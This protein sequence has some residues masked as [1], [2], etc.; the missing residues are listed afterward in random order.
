M[1]ASSSVDTWE[2][3]VRY[4][5]AATKRMDAHL[6]A[7]FG[8]SL[9]DYD[10]LR[11]I[12]TAGEPIR[13]GDLADRLL[14][15]KSSCNRIVVRLVD[16]GLVERHTLDDDRRVTLVELS[17]AGRRAWRR[18][19]AVHTRDIEKYFGAPLTSD[20]AAAVDV[21][22]RKLIAELP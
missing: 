4:H 6:H 20:D 11:Q 3:L 10:V 9:D 1:T 18:M 14:V 19:A 15:A 5:R 12:T 13:M 21:A 17:S 8:R 16:A 22:M 2:R 7:K